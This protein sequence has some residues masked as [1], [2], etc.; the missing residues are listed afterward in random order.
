MVSGSTVGLLMNSIK[1]QK[2][3]ETK[4]EGLGWEFEKLGTKTFFE[5]VTVG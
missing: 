5:N 1:Q 2:S 3:E 4:V